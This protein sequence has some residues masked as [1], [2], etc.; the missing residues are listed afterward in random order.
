MKNV[1]KTY[2]KYI[3]TTNKGCSMTS[4]KNNGDLTELVNGT[5]RF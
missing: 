3:C 4:K 5:L 1:P 2:I